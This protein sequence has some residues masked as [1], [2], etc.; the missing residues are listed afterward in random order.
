MRGEWSLPWRKDETARG[1]STYVDACV[2]AIA[3]RSAGTLSFQALGYSPSAMADDAGARAGRGPDTR[4]RAHSRRRARRRL[5]PA[6][7]EDVAQETLLLLSTKYAHVAAAEELVALA[8][9]IAALQALRRIWRKAKRRRALGETPRHR[10]PRTA[11]QTLSSAAESDAPDP[12]AIA[13]DR[14]RLS[15]LVEAV[16]KLEGKCREILR[17]K[18]QGASFVEIASELGRPVNTVYSWDLSLPQAP[19]GAA[20]RPL[21]VRVR[22][23]GGRTMTRDPKHLL[24]GLR[25]RLARR[26][27]AARA[28]A[29]GARRP[30]ALRRARRGGGAARA[31]AG[32]GR[33]AGAAGRARAA[34]SVGAPARVVREAGDAP[35]PRGRR[36]RS[37][38]RRSWATGCSSLRGGPLSRTP[39]AAARPVGASLSPQHVAALLQQPQREAVPAGIEIADRPDAVF[40]PGEPLHLRISLRAPARVALLHEPPDGAGD[41]GVARARAAA[42]PRS[43]AELGR[44]GDPAGVSR[45]AA[46]AG[47]ASTAAGRRAPSISTSARSMRAR[48]RGRPSDST[49]VD[50]RYQVNK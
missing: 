13:R 16:A 28:A 48:F 9:R 19:Q 25:D 3:A 6:D 1:I 10:R 27:R 18:L 49:L 23:D 34:D 38:S 36:R 47:D 26:G 5:V 42:R 17:R 8:A 29:R 12:E 7:A 15:M 50:L 2:G 14:Q 32:P 33:A 21:A 31:A 39:T 45:G 41:A 30:V 20:R 40:R 4:A 24:R 35:R 22:A 37:C 46:H 44:A 43:S 11:P